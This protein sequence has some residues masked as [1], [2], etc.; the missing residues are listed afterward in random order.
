MRIFNICN[1]NKCNYKVILISFG[2]GIICF[3]I[4]KYTSS[5]LDFSNIDKFSTSSIIT[6]MTTDVTNVQNIFPDAEF[7]PND[8]KSDCEV[9]GAFCILLNIL[10]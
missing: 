8:F 7:L 4:N 5:K 1:F 6:R 9:L 10:V 3:I 2:I